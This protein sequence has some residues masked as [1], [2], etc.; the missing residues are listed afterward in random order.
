MKNRGL[1]FIL[2]FLFCATITNAQDGIFWS[3]E[4]TF[5][6]ES[7]SNALF[8]TEFFVD[9]S[10]TNY[11]RSQCTPRVL[12]DSNEVNLYTFIFQCHGI[13]GPNSVKKIQ[14]PDIGIRL[15]F[16]GKAHK[17]YHKTIRVS[18]QPGDGPIQKLNVQSIN[19]ESIFN[20]QKEELTINVNDKG[21]YFVID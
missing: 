15:I 5:S 13:G 8:A 3:H 11:P 21:E 20:N 19:V 14:C 9:P 12:K 2:S 4:V 10:T 18:F 17:P 1:T 7:P 6:F 16:K